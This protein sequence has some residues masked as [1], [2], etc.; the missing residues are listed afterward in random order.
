MLRITNR[1]RAT[2]FAAI[3][4][5][6]LAACQNAQGGIAGMSGTETLGTLGGAVAGGLLG[7]RFGGGA[8]KLATTAIGT[9]LGAY[10]GQQLASRFSPSDQNRAS[11]A[12]ERAVANNQTITWNNPQSGNRGTIQPVRTYQGSGGQTCRDYNHTVVIDGQTQ[13]ARGS[14][15][16]QADGSWRLMS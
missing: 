3:A 11:D 6:S 12:E 4:A 10:A 1:L 14:A 16:R 15:C 13:V 5:L 7:S 2:A 9:L 8:G